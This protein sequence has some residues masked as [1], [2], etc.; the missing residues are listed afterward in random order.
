MRVRCDNCGNSI[1]F[2]EK[3]IERFYVKKPRRATEILE[4][5][6]DE[7]DP[8]RCYDEYAFVTCPKCSCRIELKEQD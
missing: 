7:I 4:I 1:W 2:G 5:V 3:D 6:L 8:D